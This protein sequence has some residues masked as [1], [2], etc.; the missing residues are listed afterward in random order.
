MKGHKANEYSS[1]EISIFTY[2]LNNCIS[3]NAEKFLHQVQLSICEDLLKQT[4]AG[5][6]AQATKFYA[7][8]NSDMHQDV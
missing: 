7:N 8:Q 3:V 4:Q 1:C 2:Y 5:G 6:V